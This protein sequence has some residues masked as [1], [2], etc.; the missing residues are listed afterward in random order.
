MIGLLQKPYQNP[1][2]GR[3]E[4]TWFTKPHVLLKTCTS[5]ERV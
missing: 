4:L 5:S 1:V 2:H 3:V